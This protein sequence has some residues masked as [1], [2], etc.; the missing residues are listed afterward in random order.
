MATPE[1]MSCSDVV[2]RKSGW[3]QKVGANPVEVESSGFED[4]VESFPIHIGS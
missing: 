2:D 1:G 3:R 4:L